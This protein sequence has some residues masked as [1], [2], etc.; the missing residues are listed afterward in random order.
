LPEGLFLDELDVV[1]E[2]PAWL[3]GLAHAPR[4][5]AV[6]SPSGGCPA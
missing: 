2:Q 5:A 1:D 4:L 3:E 6:S